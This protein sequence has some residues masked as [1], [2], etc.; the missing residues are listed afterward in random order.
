VY[1]TFLLLLFV[2]YRRVSFPLLSEVYTFLR[3]ATG[4]LNVSAVSVLAPPS[5]NVRF[6]ASLAVNDA[7]TMLAVGAPD[8]TGIGGALYVFSAAVG[9]GAWGAQIKL[10]GDSFGFSSGNQFGASLALNAAGDTLAVGAPN[11]SAN[12]GAVRVFVLSGGSWTVQSPILM[13][14]LGFSAVGKSLAL[15]G[16]GD[17]LAAGAHNDAAQ[18]QASGAVYTYQRNATGGWSFGQQVLPWDFLTSE[19]RY[20]GNAL[21]LSASGHTLVVGSPSEGGT[22][23]WWSVERTSAANAHACIEA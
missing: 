9:S 7:G 21:A 23:A 8:E 11:Y 1:L 13:P 2:V 19:Y 12:R 4:T 6:G 5:P 22:G 18:G 3:T 15:N 14:S 17:M 10:S 16:A 20:F